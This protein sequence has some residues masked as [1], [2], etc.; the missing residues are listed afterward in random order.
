MTD[1]QKNTEALFGRKA[2]QPGSTTTQ[3]RAWQDISDEMAEDWQTQQDEQGFALVDPVQQYG[4]GCKHFRYILKQFMG[5][6]RFDPEGRIKVLGESAVAFILQPL[7]IP[8]VVQ[9]VMKERT[10]IESGE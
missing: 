9:E 4:I 10:M 7:E 8:T 1:A 6:N 2:S 3:L 5:V